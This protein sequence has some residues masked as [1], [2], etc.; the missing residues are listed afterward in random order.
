MA[1]NNELRA[2]ILA[3]DP[4]ASVDG[5]NNKELA[6]FLAEAKAPTDTVTD[7]EADAEAEAAAVDAP[8]GPTIAKGKSITSKR[9]ILAG[10][11]SVTAGDLAG[12]ESAF[13]AL[14]KAGHITGA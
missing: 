14:V 1:S 8:A 4:H 7:A 10:G 9:G 3:I 13:A 11:D 2:Q 5:L 12:G 6:A